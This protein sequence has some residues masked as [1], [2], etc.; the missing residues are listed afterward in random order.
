MK[1]ITLRFFD[2]EYTSGLTSTDTLVSRVLSRLSSQASQRLMDV[3]KQESNKQ[4][5]ISDFLNV[6]SGKMVA[7]TSIRITKSKDVPII[8]EAMLKQNQFKVSS[9]NKNAKDDE[10]TCLDYFYFCL[11]DNKLIV[12]LDARSG[13]SRFETYLNWLLSTTE[14]GENINI[15]PTVDEDNISVSDLKK[16]TIGNSYNISSGDTGD[17]GEGIKSKMINLAGD[18]IKSLFSD[19]ESFA[20]LMDAKICSANLVI[21]FSKPRGMKEEEYKKKTAGA[22]L[23]PLEDPDSVRFQTKGKKLLGSQ[24]L[25]VEQIEVEDVDGAINEQEVYQKIIKKMS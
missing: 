21:K 5:L 25:K 19:T 1:T 4:D 10:K 17:N 18:V 22:I 16:I 7:G 12:T 24:I 9:I 3:N 15:T 2:V 13:I 11:S 6:K 14:T 20:D 23:K 8:T